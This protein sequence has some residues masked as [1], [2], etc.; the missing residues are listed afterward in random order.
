MNTQRSPYT[1]DNGLYHLYV[2]IQLRDIEN[3]VTM[4]LHEKK[5]LK[6]VLMSIKEIDG[7]KSCWINP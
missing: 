5:Q 2:D 7:S 3:D 6:A 1:I 4:S